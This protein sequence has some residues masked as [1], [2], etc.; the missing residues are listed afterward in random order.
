[1]QKLESPHPSE[2]QDAT[3]FW[4]RAA[5][6][7]SLVDLAHSAFVRARVAIS[8]LFVLVIFLVLFL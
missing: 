3:G 6:S 5:Y 1:M 2:L 7:S 8:F 4:W